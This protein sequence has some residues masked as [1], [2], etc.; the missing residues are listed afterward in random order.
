MPHYLIGVDVGG[1]FTD[2]VAY[3]HDS[4]S[5]QVWKNLSTPSDPTDGILTGLAR[6]GDL[7]AIGHLRLGTTVATNAILERQGAVVAYIATRG[8]RDVP[9]IQRGNRRYHYDITWIKPAP[10]VQHRHCLEVD[11][12]ID[13]DGHVVTALDEDGVRALA[14]ELKAQG[15]VEAIAVN[16]LFSFLEPRHEQRIKAILND[17]LPA[18]PVSISYDVLPRW[19]EYERASTTIADAYLKPLITRYLDTMQQRFLQAGLGKNFVVMKSNGGEMTLDAAAEAPIQMAVSGP[20]GGVI[21]AKYLARQLDIDHLVS[22][23]MGGTST[24]CSTVVGGEEHFTTDFEIE[25]GLPIQIPMIDI[26]TIGAGGGSIAWIDKGG[27]L[28]V[29]PR[30][31]GAVPGP[32]CY[33]QGGI[34]AT[35]TDANVVLGR[36]DPQHFL[37]GTMQ[38]D[39]AAARQAVAVLADSIGQTPE[40]TAQAIVRIAN[41]NIVGA[42][43]SVLLERGL[44]P[45][46]FTLLA[47]GGAGPVHVCDLMHEAGIPKGL[48]PV[49]PGQFSAYGFIITD[50]RVDRH[51]TVQLS[52]LN[53]EPERASLLL[54]ELVDTSLGE[55]TA[56]G[57]SE[58]LSIT[59]SMEM[60]Y[61]GQNYELELPLSFEAFTADNIVRVWQDFHDLHQARFGF[62]VP[63]SIIEVV[64][65]M[66]TA[67]ALS[68]KPALPRL[69][70][71]QAAAEPSASRTVLFDGQT[72]STPVYQRPALLAGHCISG[73][74]LI[75]EAASVT[76]LRPDMCL[77]VD[78][79]GNLLIE[80]QDKANKN[81]GTH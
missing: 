61:L 17:E 39:Q 79:M 42:L 10:L 8:F 1:T 60:R 36:I 22:L 6:L 18:I 46:D 20:S 40:D 78:R 54:Q 50:A 48:V 63:N 27:L 47:I 69:A 57:Y 35:V 37:G 23:D 53:F 38:L 72:I 32:A 62:C 77:T 11:E 44:D 43:R 52:S 67:V 49:H 75:E 59:R 56:Q 51:R 74:A 80:Q 3:E 29:G 7:D 76:V 66:V 19:K 30:S 70:Q 24:D 15:E 64:N 55:L 4:Q 68:D 12:R 73:P 33:G 65:F 31:A 71:A 45:R 13:R 58:N 41:N 2:F 16:L 28:R 26:R 81:G 5:V 25:W 34:D 9:F 14:R 21:G